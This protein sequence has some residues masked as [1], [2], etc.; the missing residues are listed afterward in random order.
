MRTL[1]NATMNL[2][3][4]FEKLVLHP[5]DDG[6]GYMTIGWGHLIKKGENFGSSITRE[7]A[8]ELLR[9][10]LRIAQAAVERNVRVGLND[11][12]Y[13]AL[14]S[15]VF[16]IGEG[17]FKKSSVLRYLNAGNLAGVP[18]RM[19]LY[20][21]SAGRVSKGLI[22]RR[23][24]EMKL[25]RTKPDN[26]GLPLISESDNE[27]S[28]IVRNGINED[29]TGHADGE[30]SVTVPPGSTATASVT[31]GPTVPTAS[32]PVEGGGPTDL[33]ILVP[34]V[35][36]EAWYDKVYSIPAKVYALLGLGTSITISTLSEI[37]GF[38]KSNSGLVL[39]VLVVGGVIWFTARLMKNRRDRESE[40][41][42]QMF[43]M[44]KLLLELRADPQKM[45]V[46]I[47]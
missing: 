1:N 16:N 45:N 9:Q 40:R 46:K 5:Y 23:A 47:E 41:N 22:R 6:Y 10:D 17:N 14:V 7:K 33:P 19:A 2:L 8:D 39:T 3:K 27:N 13:G 29:A 4:G 32:G 12:Q 31:S 28:E 21:K 36:R 34:E 26:T 25:F 43:E 35:K 11:N 18:N 24:A 30:M 20:N 15:F 44:Q 37:V 38:A 42:K